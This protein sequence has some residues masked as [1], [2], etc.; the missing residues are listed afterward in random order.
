[1]SNLVSGVTSKVRAMAPDY[2]YRWDDSLVRSIIHLA[3]L[4]VREGADMEWATHDITLN[5]GAYYYALP[6]DAVRIQSVMYASDGINF[7]DPLEPVEVEDIDRL[8]PRWKDDTG[9]PSCYVL[10]SVPGVTGYSVIMLWR[11][12]STVSGEKIRI[13][14]LRCLE[15]VSEIDAVSVPDHI[16][17][18]VYL[19]Y[20]LGTLRAQEQP[21]EAEALMAE[22]KRGLIRVRGEFQH[23]GDEYP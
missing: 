13:N 1:M 22:Y 2:A 4:A 7:Q 18:N 14:Y 21:N 16:Q 3:D 11:A 6:T 23:R 15:T 9:T 12:L 5:D 20:V 8:H 10:W 17:Q 19:P